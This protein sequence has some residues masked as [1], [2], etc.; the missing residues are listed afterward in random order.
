MSEVVRATWKTY[1]GLFL[2]C[3]AT[4]MDE[5]LLT[6]IFSVTMWYHFAFGAISIAMFGMTIGAIRV[7]QNPNL[8]EYVQVKRVMARS[9]LA[10]AF[11]TVVSVAVH[12]SVPFAGH[13]AFAILWILFSY[14]L[15]AIPFYFSGICVSIA[16]T[17]FPSRSSALYAA[18]LTGAATGCLL[19][20]Y[21]LKLTDAPTAVL[22]LA[23]LAALAA[24]AFASD[25]GLPRLSRTAAIS[26]ATLGALVIVNGMLVHKQMSPLRV[27][28]AKGRAESRPLYEKWNSFSR[29]TV[30]GDPDS[31]TGVITEGI[32]NIYTADQQVRQLQLTIDGSAA[33]T[34]T[35]FDGTFSGLEY[36]QYDVKNIV[37]HLHSNGR[38]LIIGAG[39]G[40]DVLS[41]ISMGQQNV[42]AVE[43]NQ[44]ILATV[45]SRFGDFSGHVD[46]T[47]KVTFVNDEA[48]SYIARTMDQFDVIEASFIDTWAST[49][50]GALSLTENSLYT[51]EAWDLFLNRLA[52]DGV[53]SFSRWYTPG[54]P[55]EVYRLTALAAA[56][57]HAQGITDTRNHILL[58]RNMRRNLEGF[59]Q[60]GAATILVSKQAFSPADI[61][62]FESLAAQMRFDIVL[63]PH[64][65]L[66]P[67][68]RSLADGQ[69]PAPFIN[70][71]QLNLSAPVDD[72]PFFFDMQPFRFLF[73]RTAQNE[74]GGLSLRPGELVIMLLL[75]VTFLTLYFILVPLSKSVRQQELR[76]SLPYWLFFS[77]IGS[78]FMLIEISQMQRLIVFLGHPTYALSVVLFTLLLSG[79]IGSFTTSA[80]ST[81]LTAAVT[82]L[83][84]LCFLLFVFGLITPRLVHTFATSTTPVRISLAIAT[85][86]P[87]GFLMGMPF[88]LGLSKAALKFEPLMPAFW[89]VNGAASICASILAMAIAM[90][91]GISAAFWTGTACYCLAL[92]AFCQFAVPRSVSPRR[93]ASDADIQS[94]SL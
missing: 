39:G 71:L 58:V 79:G 48:R 17:K 47:P 10:F 11:T 88:P 6:R 8:Y 18:D 70:S 35:H 84:I 50:A 87:L 7:Y 73:R 46:R 66:D 56:A 1:I 38:V 69:D 83:A 42:R 59:D 44:S 24:M 27:T 14:G 29:I 16:L 3:L 19:I 57:L 75:G 31:A 90:N 12:L 63:S 33:T 51:L 9:C 81:R 53:L 45:N 67:V 52:P 64:S 55:A 22:V 86:F 94:T 74:A 23:L 93:I 78:G 15:L 36:L 41:A 72:I 25:G 30:D 20:I 4:I 34:I 32:S 92:L 91:A 62:R 60:I 43:I 68:F 37:H 65:A 21:C 76:G 89:G 49:A 2:I 40:R 61:E 13:P 85:L 5:I 82:C 80:V 54:V 28:W 26:G 77:A